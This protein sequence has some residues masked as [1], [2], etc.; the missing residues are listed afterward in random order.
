MRGV[1]G[2]LELLVTVCRVLVRLLWMVVLTIWD[3]AALTLLL[4]PTLQDVMMN[5]LVGVGLLD[6]AMFS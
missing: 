1:A 5:I 6:R 2:V 3:V 4:L